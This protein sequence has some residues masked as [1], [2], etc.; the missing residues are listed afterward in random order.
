MSAISVTLAALSVKCTQGH[1][2]SFFI[3]KHVDITGSDLREFVDMTQRGGSG[4]QIQHLV[5][6]GVVNNTEL[7][8]SFLKE[9]EQDEDEKDENK[10]ENDEESDLEEKDAPPKAQ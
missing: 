2:R 7:L 4:C 10:E 9:K 8:E 1:F 6:V 5:L 3:S